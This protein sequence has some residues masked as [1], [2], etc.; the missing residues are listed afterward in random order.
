MNAKFLRI[1][2][3]VIGLALILPGCLKD[4][5]LSKSNENSSGDAYQE[6]VPDDKEID[7][8]T[9]SPL[10]LEYPGLEQVRT[11]VEAQQWGRAA[12]ELQKYYR[13]RSNVINPNVNV[14]TTPLSASEQSYADYAL[15]ANDY[16]FYVKG[17]FE[18]NPTNT[19]PYSY[20]GADG[21]IDWKFN[22]TGEQEQR[23][24]VHRHQ[25]FVAQ[26]KAYKVSGDAKYLNNWMA[27]YDHWWDNN[28]MPEHCNEGE[29]N[30]AIAGWIP[31]SVA[32]RVID[33]CDLL[34]Y[35]KWADAFTPAYLT[36]FV[37]RMAAQVEFIK[38]NYW[39]SSNHRISQAQAVTI[40]GV[41]FPEMKNAS[42]WVTSGSTILSE[43]V[44]K[45]YYADGWLKDNDLSY[46]MGSIESFRQA[47]L[48][49]TVNNQQ[50]RFN[51]DYVAAI[52]KM[53]E[54]EKYLIYPN[55]G[56][57]NGGTDYNY[58]V[59]NMGDSRAISWTRNVMLRHMRNY[60]DLFPD[61]LGLKWL[62]SQGV[63]GEVPEAGVKCF[64][65]GGHYAI[66][67]GWTKQATMLVAVNA[68]VSP[69]EQWHRQWD[70]NSF[71]LYVSGRQFFPD[72]G[73]F[74][75]G[76]DSQSNADRVKYAASAAHTTL[77][78]DGKT[79]SVCKGKCLK[80]ET[81][82][83]TDLLVLENPSYSTLTH[84]RAIFFV[85]HKFFVIVD[86]GYGAAAGNV[87]LNFHLLPGN[88]S[89]VVFDAADNGAHTAF[90]D[91]N[92]ILVRTFAA[93]SL[94]STLR[95]GF[96]S[97]NTG[98]FVDRKSYQVDLAKSAD[99]AAA[100]FITVIYPSQ[101]ASEAI[102]AS[103]ADKGFSPTG[104]A[105]KVSINGRA[106]NLSYTL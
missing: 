5:M 4:D 101:D 86:E 32:A 74:S 50:S 9:F 105:V 38:N 48:V 18:D 29:D 16:R 28:P 60:R 85:D 94:S 17:Y 33:G 23:Y 35:Y 24:Q 92:N 70:N 31:L 79:M 54:V 41:L 76:G 89:E 65:D 84:R 1:P 10:N 11:A 61:D 7:A 19:I 39:A 96:L 90:S 43:E 81:G 26:A 78:L 14:L 87:N 66:R 36:R 62:A 73:V 59:P 103:F 40:A 77:T 46:H 6:P 55:Y 3:F 67:N 93:E 15:E 95:T 57:Y 53:V 102:S 104:A 30:N 42:E 37:S 63:E 44:N 34:E 71:E 98:I 72:S 27:V 58:S 64:T 97:V 106:Y 80:A 8:E 91:K 20:K 13:N 22:P 68:C 82:A 75:Y 99:M 88:G 100:R 25:W 52:R 45:Q 12:L 69:K 47:M 51:A 21:Q 49:A 83:Q 2:V 56:I